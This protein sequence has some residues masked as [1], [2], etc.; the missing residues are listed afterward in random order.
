[1]RRAAKRDQSEQAIVKVL[2]AAGWE[3]HIIGQPVDLLA[4]KGGVIRLLEA[5]TPTK[6]GR[7][8]KRK[9]QPKQ[10]EFCERHGIPRVGTPE[11]AL[12]ALGENYFGER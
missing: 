9:D 10:N 7:I 6:T 8:P 11:A 3:V 5:K 4:I 1:M 2:R 12:E